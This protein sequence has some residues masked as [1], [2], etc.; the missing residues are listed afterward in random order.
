MLTFA[1]TLSFFLVAVAVMAAGVILGGRRLQ[2]SC[3]GTEGAS[4]ACDEQKRRRCREKNP[5]PHAEKPIEVS[6]LTRRG[7]PEPL[8]SGSHD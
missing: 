4:C 8:Q 1:A 6:A 7:N 2:G 3:G 5:T